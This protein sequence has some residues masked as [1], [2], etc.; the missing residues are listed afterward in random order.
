MNINDGNIDCNVYISSMTR[1][2]PLEDQNFPQGEI[3]PR[4][5]TTDLRGLLLRGVRGEGG[6]GRKGEGKVERKGNLKG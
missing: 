2:S 5:G 4:L 3:S 1:I 6:R